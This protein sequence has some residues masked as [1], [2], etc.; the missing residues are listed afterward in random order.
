MHHAG[1]FEPDERFDAVPLGEAIETGAAM[2]NDTLDQVRGDAGVERAVARAGH[3]GDAGLKVGVHGVEA[4]AAMDPGSRRS[5]YGPRPRVTKMG[6][7]WSPLIGSSRRTRSGNFGLV[8]RLDRGGTVEK[9]R[10]ASIRFTPQRIHKFTR[11]NEKE[12]IWINNCECS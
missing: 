9:C 8:G 1:E 12:K 3:D 5:C 10:L 6:S 2:L 7:D 11:S 4:R